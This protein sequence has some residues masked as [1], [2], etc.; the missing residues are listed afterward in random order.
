MKKIFSKFVTLSIFL[1]MVSSSTGGAVG[2]Y[3]RQYDRKDC[4]NNCSDMLVIEAKAS[5]EFCKEKT[6]DLEEKNK[7]LS[8]RVEKLEKELERHK[9]NDYH[10]FGWKNGGF[11]KGP[12]DVMAR[13]V[14]SL[15]LQFFVYS[16]IGGMMFGS[17]VWSRIK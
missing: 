8:A 7:E 17:A 5:S 4:N 3:S 13:Y 14:A 11:W 12:V 16:L 10:G 2:N 6:K 1:G 9:E 15:P